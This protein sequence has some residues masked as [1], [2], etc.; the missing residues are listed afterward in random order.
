MPLKQLPGKDASVLIQPFLSTKEDEGTARLVR[1]F[2]GV[3]ARGYLTRAELEAVCFWKSARAIHYVRSNSDS[4]IRTA[5]RRALATRDERRRL[6]AL[7][8]L[9]GVAVPMASSILM[10][11]NPR[12][13]GVIDIRVWQLL[14]TI[15]AVTKKPAGTGFNVNDWCQFLAI[16]RSF[17][18]A[19]NVTARD[20][21]RALFSVHLRHQ[22]GRL[23]A[24]GRRRTS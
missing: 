14:H 9:R 7:T 11:V 16:L 6:E 5:T 2:R 8:G 24:S 4:Q 21:E 12:R 19:L 23:Y 18:A 3:R 17:A 1:R 13:Y 20:V 10:F 22:E 15:G